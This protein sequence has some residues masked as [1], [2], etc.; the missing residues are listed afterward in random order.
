MFETINNSIDFAGYDS[1]GSIM[2]H[3]PSL[4]LSDLI[5]F[6]LDCAGSS[7]L[8]RPTVVMSINIRKNYIF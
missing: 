7:T 1:P 3:E 5:S 4:H 8:L 2:Y 6:K